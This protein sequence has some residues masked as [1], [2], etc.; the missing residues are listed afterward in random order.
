MQGHFEQAHDRHY[1]QSE[2]AQTK[3]QLETVSL[4]RFAL[5]A[6]TERVAGRPQ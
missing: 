6:M 5:L 4:D 1:E 2:A 3:P